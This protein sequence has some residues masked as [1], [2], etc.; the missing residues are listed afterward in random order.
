KMRI[1]TIPYAEVAADAAAIQASQDTPH[2]STRSQRFCTA[3]HLLADILPSVPES[4]TFTHETPPWTPYAYTLW[5]PLIARSQ[6]LRA[7]DSAVAQIPSFLCDDLLRCH[8]AWVAMDRVRQTL[9]D[10]VVEAWTA[11]RAGREVARLFDGERKWFVRLDQMSPKDSPL[12]GKLPCTTL[13]EVVMRLGSSMRV[14]GCLL[15]EREDALREGREMRIPIVCN[16]WDEGMDAAREFR[17]FV[18]PPG[19]RMSYG[20]SFDVIVKE[21]GVVQVV[22]INPFGALSGCGACLFNWA[23]DGRVL[24][25]LDGG[26]VEFAVTLEE[27][28]GRE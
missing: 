21:G 28:E 9:V 4:A 11:T 27:A 8:A 2:P 10:E 14:Y 19:A 6:R 3:Q 25:G 5:Q 13:E 26:E 22:E 18:P 24:Y 20:F 1:R 16:R 23:R 17:V 12:G 15:R 7:A